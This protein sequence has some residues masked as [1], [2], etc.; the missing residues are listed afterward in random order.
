MLSVVCCCSSM[1]R[2]AS[3]TANYRQHCPFFF[4]PIW[5]I[6]RAGETTFAILPCSGWVA[7]RLCKGRILPFAEVCR[8]WPTLF[9]RCYAPARL[10]YSP[11]SCSSR[12]FC[13]SEEHTSELQSRE[14]LVCRL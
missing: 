4:L 9:L 11:S 8:R 5:R 7:F 13:R 14:N 10:N 1:A 12:Y 3:T 6:I 2:H